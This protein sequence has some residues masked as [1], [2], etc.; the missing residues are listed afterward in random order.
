MSDP[1]PQTTLKRRP[2]MDKP[3]A[4]AWEMPNGG[5]LWSNN[6]PIEEPM[7]DSMTSEPRTTMQCQWPQ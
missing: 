3:N 4:L 6:P 5:V 7:V 1:K 2:D